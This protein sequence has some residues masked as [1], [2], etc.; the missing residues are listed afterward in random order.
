MFL[1]GLLD[2]LAGLTR[3]GRCDLGDR[4]AGTR[5]ADAVGREAD[6]LEDFFLKVLV[7]DTDRARREL[8]AVE[9]HVIGP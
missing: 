2:L 6:R 4:L 3:R 7:V 8:V 9:D 1:G 5:P